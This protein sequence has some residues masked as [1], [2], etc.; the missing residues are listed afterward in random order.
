MNYIS[1]IA[2]A[3]ILILFLG[4]CS[5]TVSVIHHDEDKAIETA[6]KLLS[7]LIKED[8]KAAYNDCIGDRLKEALPYKRFN[9]DVKKGQQIRGPIKKAIFDSYMPVPRQRAI[10]LF[11][12]VEHEQ[13]GTIIYHFVME[14]D[15][16]TGYRVV[17]VDVGN[18]M[19]YPPNSAFDGLKKIKKDKLIVVNGN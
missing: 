14:G 18:Q 6:N 13:A 19:E 10:Q 1:T 16:P 3:L 15:K 8:Y 9:S 17:L 12:S 7:Y 2:L 5:P 4:G 11:Y